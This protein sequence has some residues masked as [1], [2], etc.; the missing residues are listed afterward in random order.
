MNVQQVKLHLIQPTS[1]IKAEQHPL[2]TTKLVFV[3]N[4][5]PEKPK[6]T[7]YFQSRVLSIGKK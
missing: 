7:G 3:K 4:N 5:M 6:N 1:P 2:P